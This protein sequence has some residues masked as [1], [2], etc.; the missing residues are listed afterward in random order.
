MTLL[1]ISIFSYTIIILL[2][3]AHY[4]RSLQSYPTLCDPR[5]HCPWNS[6]GKNAGVG[7]LLLIRGSSRL[8]NQTHASYLLRWQAGSSPLA[9]PQLSLAVLVLCLN[10][11]QSRSLCCISLL[12]LFNLFYS[13]IV[14]L[15]P[16]PVIDF[17]EENRSVYLQNT[18]HSFLGLIFCF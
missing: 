9:P 14:L 13:I 8:G 7:C 5:L 11:I 16:S 12:Y 6:P 2:S 18:S 3:Q 10:K 1:K 17:F 4:A 15:F